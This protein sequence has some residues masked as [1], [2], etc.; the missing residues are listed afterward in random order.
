[1]HGQVVLQGYMDGSKIIVDTYIG[2][3]GHVRCWDGAHVEGEV[4]E[5]GADWRQGEG[6]VYEGIGWHAGLVQVLWDRPW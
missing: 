5:H 1:M 3:W 2:E 4:V 6:W